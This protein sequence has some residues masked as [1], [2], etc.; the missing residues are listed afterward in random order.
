[1]KKTILLSLVAL[2]FSGV[3]FASGAMPAAPIAEPDYFSGFNLGVNVGVQHEAGD[4]N[5]NFVTTYTT[6]SEEFGSPVTSIPYSLNQSSDIGSTDF[7]AGL[8]AAYGQTFNTSFYAGLEAFG[9][10]AN[11]K[12]STNLNYGYSQTTDGVTSYQETGY[13]T[14]DV[15]TDWAFGGDVKL[16]YLVT[17]KTMFYVLAGVEAQEINVDVNHFLQRQRITGLTPSNEITAYGYSFEKTKAAFMPGVG[18]E[19]ML[20]DKLALDARYTYAWYGSLSG[21]FVNPTQNLVPGVRVSSSTADSF[22]NTDAKL[23]RGLYTLGL[24]YHFNGI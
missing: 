3:T 13:S 17:P 21:G 19:T 23:N 16:G 8:S 4:V 10:Y 12:P 18:I 14:V 1:M 2:G 15:K 11:A 24:T 7:N 9:R 5:N 6:V 22:S 20:T